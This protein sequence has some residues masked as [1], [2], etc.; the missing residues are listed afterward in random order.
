MRDFMSMM[1]MAPVA[2]L[3][4]NFFGLPVEATALLGMIVPMFLMQRIH[5][6]ESSI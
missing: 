3:L 2:A 1:V 6:D 5:S 4:M